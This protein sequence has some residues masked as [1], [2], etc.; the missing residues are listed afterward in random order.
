MPD[1]AVRPAVPSDADAIWAIQRSVLSEDLAAG[2]GGSLPAQARER[3]EAT[4]GASTW[5]E[6][7]AHIPAGGLVVVATRNERVVGYAALTPLAQPV[8]PTGGEVTIDAEISALDVRAADQRQGH[9]SRLLAALMEGASALEHRGVL[10]WTV[11]A[12]EARIRFLTSAGFAPLGVKRTLEL[13]VEQVAFY[14]AT[15]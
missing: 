7:L 14:T 5:R 2:L 1:F 12:Q 15:A 6:T 11:A 10:A 13:D 8:S 4:D 9:G 3:I